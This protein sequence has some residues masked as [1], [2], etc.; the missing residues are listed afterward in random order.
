[1]LHLLSVWFEA[2]SALSPHGFC[3]LW[4]PGLIWSFVLG[5][6]GTA[7]AYFAIPLALYRFVRL[8]ADLVLK[9]VFWL[10]ATFILLCGTTHWLD[11]ATIWIPVY[12]LEAVSKLTTA[13]VSI[14]TAVALWKLLPQALAFASPVQVQRIN[15]A[16]MASEEQLQSA[17]ALLERRIEKRTMEL[18]A[19][20]A[21]SRDLLSTLALGTFMIL[22]FERKIQFWSEGCHLLYGWTAEEATGRVSHELLHT[23][24][25]V[26][27]AEMEAELDTAGTWT[28]ELSHR[29]RDGREVFV[30]ARMVLRRAACGRPLSV[31]KATTD[32]T[33]TRAAE[34]ER[35]RADSLLRGVI[36]ATPGLIYAKDLDGRMLLANKAVLALLGKSWAEVEGRTDVEFLDDPQ[37][38]LAVVANDRRIMEQGCTEELEER[39]G[40]QDSQARIWLSTKTPLRGREGQVEGLV[41]VS[42]EITERKKA[43]N[44]LNLM[45]HELNH[46]V[47]NCLSTVQS[48]VSQTL[49]G[50][51]P[52]MKAVLDARLQALSAA[53]DVL[54]RE[55][56][57]S[58]GLDEVV[59]AA[60]AP[61]GGLTS[62][63]FRVSGP[64]VRLLP[65]AALAFAMAFHELATNALKY[66]ALSP[67][68]L[69]GWVGLDWSMRQGLLHLV[70][71]EHG[72][73]AVKPPLH[74]GFGTRLIERMLAQD[75]R[76]PADLTFAPAGLIC[77]VCAPL[78]KIGAAQDPVELLHV[79]GLAA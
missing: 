23:V 52:E 56:W 78:D 7:V 55:A 75:L 15:A 8:R 57:Q 12:R 69:D 5:D 10:F 4:E 46:R 19:S 67:A 2:P 25:P 43:E 63:Y 27:M 34:H 13:A 48:I 45:V 79:G 17:N 68:A 66:G 3:L 11:L 72:G 58:A 70:W 41:G 65:K 59:A 18:Q 31:L 64:P 73:P 9:P 76:G 42:V 50:T 37:Q 35:H 26:S 61:Y 47:K 54:T 24:F 6:A 22:D 33:E 16:L 51:E 29:T 60:L 21:Q 36:A 71:R 53:H 28:G 44:R 62:R 20:E 32:L 74:R 1:L 14:A 30:A 40:M 49:R 38:G 77:T 39:V